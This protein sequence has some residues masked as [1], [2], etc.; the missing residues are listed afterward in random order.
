MIRKTFG[1]LIALMLV[2]CISSFAF[3]RGAPTRQ[4]AFASNT[5]VEMVSPQVATVPV[6]TGYDVIQNLTTEPR[7]SNVLTA[8]SDSAYTATRQSTTGDERGL[9]NRSGYGFGRLAPMLVML[10]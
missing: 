2:V 1:M 8:V 4:K 9:A 3:A 10:A 5:A 7:V 6:L